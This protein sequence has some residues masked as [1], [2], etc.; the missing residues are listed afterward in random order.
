MN[1]FVKIIFCI[2]I[3]ILAK[4]IIFKGS[5]FFHVVPSSTEYIEGAKNKS[6][7]SYNLVPFRSIYQFLTGSTS[8][9]EFFFN[10][11]GN[12]LLFVP[13]GFLLP[14]IWRKAKHLTI[15]AVSAGFLSLLFE[16]YQF[17]TNT[18]QLDVDDI[19]LNLMGGITGFLLFSFGSRYF[20]KTR[21]KISTER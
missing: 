3:L 9:R 14:V 11:M 7:D 6:I 21:Y 17:F 2:Y 1:V 19:I 5:L 13:F 8:N 16:L 10:I 12:I 18:G 4:L 15:V 20:L